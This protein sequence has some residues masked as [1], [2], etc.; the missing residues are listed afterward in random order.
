[1]L[2]SKEDALLSK[3][4]AQQPPEG[5]YNASVVGCR[6]VHEDLRI[7][8]VQLDEGRLGFIAGQYTTLGL[9]VGRPSAGDEGT[10]NRMATNSPHLTKRAYSISC[11]M[12][13]SDDELVTVSQCPYLEFYIT[14][15]HP[16]QDDRP[17][18]SPRLFALTVGERLYVDRRAHGR[19]TL[20]PVKPDD[21]VI[22][23]A[24][25]TGEA[26]HNA[27]VAELLAGSH[28][29]RIVCVTC[30][31]YRRDLGYL[32]VHRQLERRYRLYR[33]VGLTTRE[34]EN[35]DANRPDY[36]GKQYLQDFVTTFELDARLGEKLDPTRTHVYL[37]G[38]PVMIGAPPRS[39]GAG[40]QPKPAGMIE[41]LQRRGF[42]MDEPGRRGN[43]HFETFW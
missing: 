42:R 8:R 6:D 28:R 16:Q 30:V 18:L 41:A 1:M 33:Y 43:I 17:H 26:P 39:A 25:G 24:T 34:P 37:C 15:V 4:N 29:G 32:A 20:E 19:Y 36:V 23:M 11:S 40:Q 12:L 21:T 10:S 7:L 31:R 14:Q 35:V 27:M 22:L 38:N 3:E 2:S 9:Y 5:L 13:N